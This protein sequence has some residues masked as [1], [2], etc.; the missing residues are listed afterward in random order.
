MTAM[1]SAAYSA[2][3]PSCAGDAD[4]HSSATS[5]GDLARTTVTFRIDCAV[6]GDLPAE[7]VPP[8]HPAPAPLARNIWL[9]RTA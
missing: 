4:W 9:G 2:P 8:V 1:Q 7:I 3:C 6:C 5:T